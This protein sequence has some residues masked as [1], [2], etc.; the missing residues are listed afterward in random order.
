MAY[1]FQAVPKRPSGSVEWPAMAGHALCVG[2]LH[3]HNG[4]APLPA[5]ERAGPKATLFGPMETG[6]G[7]VA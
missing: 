3:R 6:P 4:L 2:S 1:R 5:L 7:K